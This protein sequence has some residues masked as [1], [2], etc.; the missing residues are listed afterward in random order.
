MPPH[1]QAQ[2]PTVKLR[3]SHFSSPLSFFFLTHS[4]T[5]ETTIP[6]PTININI[7][8]LGIAR[9]QLH[10]PQRSEVRRSEGNEL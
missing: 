5:A 7:L 3:K 4:N 1:D 6:S 2:T 8:I 9:S 10:D